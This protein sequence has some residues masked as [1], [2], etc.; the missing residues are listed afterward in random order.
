V[1]DR[2]SASALLKSVIA[3]VASTTIL[4]LGIQS[5]SASQQYQRAGRIMTVAEAGGYAFRAMHNL[6]TER[7][8][9]VRGLN[10]PAPVTADVQKRIEGHRQDGMGALQNLVG[11]LA[12]IEFPDRATLY[13]EL[14]RAVKALAAF[15]VE[16]WDALKKPKEAR[17]ESLAQEYSN[18]VLKLLET[19]DKVSGRLSA[20]VKLHDA[21]VD[22]MLMVKHLAWLVR[23]GG[24]DASLMIS[25]GIAAGRL[26]PDSLEKYTALIGGN[27]SAWAALESAVAGLALPPGL[28]DAIATAKKVYFGPEYIAVR[29]KNLKTLIAG[30]K[31]EMPAEQWAP[32]TVERLA[33][34]LAVAEQA[35]D[36]AHQHAVAQRGAARTELAVA[37]LLLVGALLLAL[38]SMV[39]VSRRVINP[40]TQIRDAMLKVAGGDLTAE[41]SFAARRDEIGALAGALQVF[42]DNAVAA[43][44]AT[45]AQEAE[46]QAKEQRATQLE[47]LTAAFESKV[48]A[49]VGALSSAATEMEATA[50]GM[51]ATAEQTNQQS[52]TVAAAAEQASANVQTVAT[53]AE[54]LSSSIAEIGRQV[55]QSST[56]AGRAVEDA[57]RTDATVRT[58]AEGAQ[59]I[60]EV[61][62][63]IQDIANQTNLLALNATIEAAR[64]GEAGKGF[65]VVA[66][67]VKTLANQT[68][69]ATEEI[70]TQI[71]QI[72]GATKEAVAAIERI[73]AVIGEVNAIAGSIAAAV[74][75][76]GAATQE[77][78]RNV[79][80]AAGGTQEV[81][82]N[83]AGVKEA[84]SGTGAAAAQV[85]GAAGGLAKHAE[86]L[87]AELDAFLAGVKAA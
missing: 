50:R 30:E 78:A 63:L 80:Q 61:V 67:E 38:G 25:N 3:V 23:D 39:A 7:S 86:E 31:P 74:E 65:A 73:V 52:M 72:Q 51:S 26:P 76:Q 19:L 77:I 40:L 70:A 81:T 18:E 42:K 83:I 75:E 22:Q 82:R 20:S 27:Q 16:A 37:G 87:S 21:T 35:L 79:Q 85:L 5:W 57:Q 60:G 32:Y 28:A 9:T 48:G 45:E 47:T 55:T 8:T 64:A 11:A 49:L 1:F 46:R 43:K 15:Q 58:L 69:K 2:L 4:L 34:L 71:G 54:E 41:V 36:A 44:Q 17:R 10:A 62:T 68:G 6:R 56:V 14:Q 84:A 13:P 29:D 66:S 24:G 59:K 12:G 53:A 33:T